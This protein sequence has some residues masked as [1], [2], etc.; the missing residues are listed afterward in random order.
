MA[1]K[2]RKE[3]SSYV[4]HTVSHA[5]DI[6]EEFVGKGDEFGVAG[7]SRRLNLQKNKVF[8]ILAT[9]EHRRYVEQNPVTG[10][11]RL[12]LKNLHLGQTF[13]N[14]M[15]L[16]RQARPVQESLVKACNETV[17]VA[18]MRD[19]QIVNLDVVESGLPVRVVPRVGQ[20]LPLYCTASGKVIAA[21]LSE[22]LLH[23]YVQ[24]RELKSYT[25]HTI[26]N[27]DELIDH[28][29]SVV[30][31]GY[32]VDDEELEDG[33]KG[34]GAPIRDY[35]GKTIGAVSITGPSERLS[36]ERMKDELIP[37]IKKSAMEI[38]RRLGDCGLRQKR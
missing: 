31:L 17:Y 32:A 4:I 13:V 20:R 18:V 23:E 5:L 19:F 8:R 28:L 30:A 2:T 1:M 6:L 24:T 26:S 14:Q 35:S 3:K 38:S 12:G 11:Y 15:G 9:L 37:L 16:L 25:P 33:V 27:P 34:V 22:H 29:K 21:A 36:A 7:L 10:N